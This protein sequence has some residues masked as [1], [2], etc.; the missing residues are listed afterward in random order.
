MIQGALQTRR[1]TCLR[2]SSVGTAQPVHTGRP[3]QQ[4]PPAPTPPALPR[5]RSRRRPH[6]STLAPADSKTSLETITQVIN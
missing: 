6:A 3:Y 1:R 5:R 2:S 4:E